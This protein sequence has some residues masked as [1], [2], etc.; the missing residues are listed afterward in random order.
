[1]DH[2]SERT[3][4]VQ[5]DKLVACAAV[6]ELFR[7]ALRSDYLAGLWRSDVLAGLLWGR[8]PDGVCTRPAVYRAPSWSWAAVEGPIKNHPTY[9]MRNMALYVTLAEVVEC[10][11]T[12]ED[13]ALP[14]GRVTDGALILRG[15]PI[16]CRGGPT[17]KRWNQYWI[18]PVPSYEEAR[19]QQWGLGYHSHSDEEEVE[20]IRGGN[21]RA[22][23]VYVVLD[24]NADEL[25][26]RMWAVPLIRDARE[27]KDYQELMVGGI[28]LE[29]VAPPPTDSGSKCEKKR[30]RRIGMFYGACSVAKESEHSLWDPLIRAASVKKEERPWTD[31]VIL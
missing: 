31:I 24:C 20:S 16:P 19:H 26:G 17:R 15:T 18:V 3:A 10:W 21:V 5:S 7:G 13:R 11:V 1:M 12:L 28:V 2:Y 29:P 14:F 22:G 27:I 8:N 30:F 23:V 6:A 9:L 4:S 25:P